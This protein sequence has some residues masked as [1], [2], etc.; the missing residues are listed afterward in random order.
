MPRPIAAA[1]RRARARALGLAGPRP[2]QV[3]DSHAHLIGT[4]D[5]AAAS[6]SI[7]A[8]DS[9]LNPGEYARASS[10][11]TPA[12]CTMPREASIARIS[13]ACKSRRRPRPG[14]K[15][16]RQAPPLRFRARARRAGEAG[17]GANRLLRPGRLREGYRE[18]ASAVLR[19]G[20]LHPSISRRRARALQRA[21]A[22][23]AAGR[24]VAACVDEY[25]SPRRRAARPFTEELTKRDL[26]LIVHC[27]EERAVLGAE[28]QRLRQSAAHAARAR[29]RPCA[30]SSRIAPRWARIATSIKA[31]TGPM[32]TA[33]RSSFRVFE[34]FN[35]A[36]GDIS[37]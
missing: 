26:P 1:P 24:E 34:K 23:G 32:S 31:R 14:R 25:R 18:G 37:R 10:S 29:G 9:L 28:Q 36:H 12:A 19:M 27:G 22:E 21:K 13:S 30:W 33:S 17:P 11:S 2:A 8:M 16:R 15:P 35:N 5:S 20:G 3:W 7:R 4:G 6:I